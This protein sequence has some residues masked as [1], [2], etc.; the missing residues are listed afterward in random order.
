[1]Y[2]IWCSLANPGP[3]VVR[4]AQRLLYETCGVIPLVLELL[5][6]ENLGF[7]RLMDHS[8][9][10]NCCCVLWNLSREPELRRPLLVANVADKMIDIIHNDI[11][12]AEPSS[13]VDYPA[14]DVDRHEG[15]PFFAGM[16]AANL[17][18]CSVRWSLKT[19]HECSPRV[20]KQVIAVKMLSKRSDGSLLTLLSNG[21]LDHLLQFLDDGWNLPLVSAQLIKL[22]FPVMQCLERGAETGTKAAGAYWHL[23][24]WVGSWSVL[25]C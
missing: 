17:V 12:P 1:M 3:P 7:D 19:H 11:V 16:T 8:T 4:R 2:V 20:Q 24:R 23:S 22:G 18:V 6:E 21:I 10:Y 13:P 14:F 5:S 25:G 15:W 9:H